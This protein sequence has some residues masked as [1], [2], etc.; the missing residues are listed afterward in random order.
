M[1]TSIR[2]TKIVGRLA[3]SPSGEMH[4]GNAFTYTLAWC[5]VRKRRGK[6]LF[7]IE[8]LDERCKRDDFKN[9]VIQDMEWLGLDWDGEI[10]FQ[11]KRTH[12][13]DEIF[14]EIMKLGLIYPCFC[15]RA[16]LHASSAPH[17]SNGTYIYSGKCRNLSMTE[18][19]E[20][21]RTKSPAYRI[22]VPDIDV[23][24]TDAIC[25]EYK[26]NLISE[27]GDFVIRRSDCVYAY[28]FAVA[29]DDYLQGVNQIVRGNDLLSSSPRQ[30]FLRDVISCIT[31]NTT[32][33]SGYFADAERINSVA[34]EIQ[35]AHVPLLTDETGRRLAKRDKD[36]TIKALREKGVLASEIIGYF[37]YILGFI[38][39]YECVTLEEL[40]NM[41]D[42]G[43]IENQNLIVKYNDLN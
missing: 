6:V 38:E 27:C 4:L 23:S 11:S 28:Q 10:A 32:N 19:A 25:G 7:R 41:F 43:K 5:S 29:V 39:K 20:K 24:I 26:Q 12:I 35:F 18:I 2:N 40:L 14:N 1:T 31:N 42:L 36:L 13:Y 22:K 15:S 37:A 21:T 30:V 33:A 34:Q 9:Q 3:P 17:N 8:D 16:D